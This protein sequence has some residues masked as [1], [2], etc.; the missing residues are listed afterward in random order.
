MLPIREKVLYLAEIAEYWSRELQ[1]VRTPPEIYSKLLSAFWQDQLAVVHVQNLHPIQRL[2]VLKAIN[3]T[4]CLM[5]DHPGFTLVDRDEMIPPKVEQQ[6]DGRWTIDQGV[7]IVLPSQDADWTA[8][9][10][11]AA[12]DQLAKTPLD[13][14]HELLKP[15]IIGLGATKEALAAYCD[16]MGWGRPKFWFGYER[17]RRSAAQRQRDFEAWLKHIFLGP[18]EKTKPMYLTNAITQ[19]PGL[20]TAVFNRTWARD[21]PESWKRSGPLVREPRTRIRQ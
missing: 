11:A 15:P 2:N 3:A 13:D 14:F 8:G 19:F 6:P 1:G 4:R 5:P 7:Y 21:A 10:L 17:P 16:L 9:I 18:K 20:P 12:Y